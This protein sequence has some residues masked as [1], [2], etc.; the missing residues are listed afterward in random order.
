MSIPEHDGPAGHGNAGATEAVPASQAGDAPESHNRTNEAV[1]AVATVG[2]VAVGAAV[3]EIALIPGIAIG[4]AAMVVPKYVPKVGS[5]LM[6]MFRAS[7]GGAYRLGHKAREM[8]AEA[9]EQL[10]DIVAEPA[11]PKART[12]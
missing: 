3:F 10:R 8:M 5:A 4:V 2:A 11:A 9:K 7:V 12:I 1:M 6:P